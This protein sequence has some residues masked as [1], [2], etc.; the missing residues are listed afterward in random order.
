MITGNAEFNKRVAAMTTQSRSL[1]TFEIPDEGL[2]IT[3]F[4]PSEAN[5]TVDI[6]F[7]V[8]QP[9]WYLAALKALGLQTVSLVPTMGFAI[10]ADDGNSAA[11]PPSASVERFNYGPLLNGAT[12]YLSWQ[13]INYPS[14]M[15][16][17][18]K[19]VSIDLVMVSSLIESGGY[20]PYASIGYSINGIPSEL[21]TWFS[22]LLDNTA[23]WLN[24]TDTLRLWPG[25]VDVGATM[26]DINKIQLKVNQAGSTTGSSP[27]GN[28]FIAEPTIVVGFL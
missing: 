14:G 10:P 21:T 4:I 5:V 2:I 26:P 25:N 17:I 6:P 28:L 15:Q 9:L 11:I 8:T 22:A 1:Y 7:L 27:S 13:G 24:R 12:S 20:L 19:A 18:R 23:G 3:S 16:D